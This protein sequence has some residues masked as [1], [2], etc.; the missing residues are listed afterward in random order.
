LFGIDAL[1]FDTGSRLPIATWRQ[2]IRR[3]AWPTHLGGRVLLFALQRLLNALS[4][5]NA[6]M[7][8]LRSQ[9]SNFGFDDRFCFRSVPTTAG[10]RINL[11]SFFVSNKQRKTTPASTGLA[12]FHLND[13][14]V[15]INDEKDQTRLGVPRHMPRLGPLVGRGILRPRRGRT[16]NQSVTIDNLVCVHFGQV[17]AVFSGR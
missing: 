5:R 4:R 6:F 3:L 9:G 12:G 15:C 11:C 13:D 14:R 16:Y 7:V 10:A 8:A 1:S 17:P 2:R